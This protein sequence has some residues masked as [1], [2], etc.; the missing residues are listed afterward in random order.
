MADLLNRPSAPV[1]VAGDMAII[2]L[3]RTAPP[4]ELLEALVAAGVRSVEVTVP[5]LGGLDAVSRWA[6][7]PGIAVGTGTVQDVE[8]S[9]PQ[10]GPAR[11]S[12]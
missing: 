3:R 1:A 8:G 4:D 6:D 10:P 2:R 7:Q 12:W 11:C 9:A 5:T